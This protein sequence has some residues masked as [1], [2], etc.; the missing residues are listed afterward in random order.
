MKTIKT[1][2]VSWLI[3]LSLVLVWGSSFILIKKG[4]DFYSP[5]ELGSLRIVIAFLCLLP[6]SF[7]RFK[8]VDRKSL[9]YILVSGVV[10]SAIPAILFSL[11]EVG[12]D[13]SSAGI[14]NSL[15]TVFTLIVGILFF[16]GTSNWINIV[17]VV[18]GLAGTVGLLT[19]SGGHSLNFNIHYGLY[20]IMATIMYAFNAN[21]IKYKLKEVDPETITILAFTMAGIPSLILLGSATDFFHQIAT[22]KE[23]WQGLIYV[24]ILG[25]IGTALAMMFYNKLI[26]N[27]SAVFASSVTYMMPVI[28]IIWGVL[29]GE[30]FKISFLSWI[31]LILLGVLMVSKRN[32]G[33]SLKSKRADTR[34]EIT[35]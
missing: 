13:S 12:L 22:D 20:I 11:A 16:R 31:L 28:A 4:L 5:L 15:T 17:G 29:D 25:A 14:L 32:V 27:I 30:T 9:Y 8:K 10:G 3:L 23:S 33:Y 2:I 35:P 6:F 34:T 26:K 7:S 24:G 18:I 19:V 21:I 1:E